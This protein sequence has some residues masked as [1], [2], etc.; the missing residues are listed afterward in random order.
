MREASVEK[1][2]KM[3]DERKLTSSLNILSLYPIILY[4][5]T[6]TNEYEWDIVFED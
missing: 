6:G 1:R 5:S 3:K 2:Q 4:Y